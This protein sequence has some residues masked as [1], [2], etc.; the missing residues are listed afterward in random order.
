VSHYTHWT[1]RQQVHL[2]PTRIHG[3][4]PP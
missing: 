4:I 2:K 3:V 1:W